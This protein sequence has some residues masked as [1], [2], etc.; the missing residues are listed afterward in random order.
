LIAAVPVRAPIYE[1]H[2]R[3]DSNE[4][5]RQ[6]FFG[7]GTEGAPDDR[8]QRPSLSTAAS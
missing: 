5:L 2:L 3:D 8:S 7:P 4:R 6:F 1:K